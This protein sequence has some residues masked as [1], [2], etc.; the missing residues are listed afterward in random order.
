MFWGVMAS[1][2]LAGLSRVAVAQRTVAASD[3][4]SGEDRAEE[5]LARP[6]TVNVDKAS[7]A[8][9]LNTIAKSARVRLQYRDALVASYTT[10]ITMHFVRTPLGVA[11]DRVLAKTSLRIVPVRD[12]SLSLAEASDLSDGNRTTGT[13]MGI[14]RDDKT[15]QPLRGASVTL[16]DSVQRTQTDNEGRYRFLTVPA[17][18]HR[19][20]VRFVGYAR[21]AVLVTVSDDLTVT[22]DFTL[23]SS[24]NTLDQVVVTATGA[25]RYRELG[26]I[27]STINA[28]SVVREAPVTS[29]SELLT[30]R[31]PGLQ[32]VT[33]NGGIV[34]GDVTL[35]IRGTST[36]YLDAAP[37]VIVDG[38]RYRS[39]N[40]VGTSE[41]SRPF[42]A[43][44]RGPL[45]DLNVND[46]ETI[47]VVK[48]PSASTLYGPDA[49]NG[50]VVI[51]TKR[52][53]AGKTEWHVY[54]YPDVSTLSFG[55][56]SQFFTAQKA[57]QGWGH[58]PN[59]TT[60]YQGQCDLFAQAAKECVL[61]S[62]TVFSIPENDPQTAALAKQRPA[63]H[64]GASVSGGTVGFQYFYS[65]NFDSETGSL[66]LPPIAADMLKQQLGVAA[67]SDAIRNPN[68]QQT[69]NLHASIASRINDATNITLVGNYTQATQRGI[70]PSFFYVQNVYAAIPD[71]GSDSAA[72]LRAAQA[73]SNAISYLSTTQ[74]DVRRLTV[75][76]NGTVQPRPWL[77]ADVSVGSD[78]DNTIDRGARIVGSQ[79]PNDQ[80]QADDQRRANTNRNA[81]LGLTMTQHP[82]ILSF[83]TSLGTDYSY[84]NMDGL[85]TDG[86]NLAPGSVDISTA[87]S[88]SVWRLWTEAASLGTFGEEVIGWRD[89]LFLTGSLRLDGSTTFGDAYTA[90]PFPKVGA[91]WVVSD[92]PLVA[93]L[94]RLGMGDVRLRYSFGASSRYPTS[95]MKLGQIGVQHGT[96]EDQT[97]T[98]FARTQLPNAK[99]LPERS[100]ESEYGLDATV[101]SV[102]QLGV[103]WYNRRSNDVLEPYGAP[104]GLLG[105]WLNAGDLSAS[106]FEVTMAVK[107]FESSR[108]ALNIQGSYANNTTK[109]LS[110][111]SASTGG[112]GLT[113]SAAVGYPLNASFGRRTL[114]V[115][116]TAGGV[117]DSI[118]S[119]PTEVISSPIEYLGVLVA[120]KTY[121]VT[122]SL[123]LFGGR[124][125]MSTL[126]D[127]QA[128]GVQYDFND[129]L[130]AGT[131][132]CTAGFLKSTPLMRQA[133]TAVGNVGDYIRTSNF[134]RWR[135]VNITGE[136]PLS[137]RARLHLSQAAVS[138]QVR[139]LALWAP[140]AGKDP[141]STVG[142]GTGSAV[143]G[144]GYYGYTG[145]PQPTTWSVRF[146]L[147]P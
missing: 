122:P 52:G 97:Q 9:A 7:L 137:L 146:D 30:A 113:G 131:H 29:L 72:I 27:V 74:Q 84:T 63:W 25:Q 14:V 6:V 104:N 98:L 95:F 38:V 92:E 57:L 80:G 5:L 108:M 42:N 126:I 24:I 138:L 116:D 10:P 119:S 36:L 44:P 18:A 22:Q 117:P 75:A 41:D 91:S 67:L 139:N 55:S 32:V 66:H 77:R 121:T 4:R 21:Q 107:V 51:T 79:D 125:R 33:N 120:P 129:Y 61:D 11:L 112:K 73:N 89:R 134:T 35:R 101:W 58:I 90:H 50:A 19:I 128:G 124:I 83:R 111:G 40:F 93:P 3:A 88:Q 13:V 48:G 144:G 46:I 140:S 68:T 118:I 114:S 71:P 65:G 69:L 31:V 86:T 23:S 56:N 103:T 34:G 127:G 8:N 142:L 54:A 136:L 105:E 106:G 96:V 109:V 26:H 85:S 53:K 135:E 141:E 70:D 1:A 20:A 123:V 64:S 47:E 39:D 37:I 28:D 147:S 12:G 115:I 15:H 45:N 110:L 76:A 130:C 100:R 81:H 94:R 16:D 82:G 59:T 60:L 43:E 78:L 2:T 145:I 49:A 99:L 133:A 62:L 143:G 17:G 102:V 87:T 132:T